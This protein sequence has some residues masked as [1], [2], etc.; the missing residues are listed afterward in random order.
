MDQGLLP[1]CMH[2]ARS[3]GEAVMRGYLDFPDIL[4]TFLSCSA[5]SQRTQMALEAMLVSKQ[6]ILYE[7]S[8]PSFFCSHQVPIND[9]IK[10]HF[11]TRHLSVNIGRRIIRRGNGLLGSFRRAVCLS[12]LCVRKLA[13]SDLARVCCGRAAFHANS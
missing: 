2:A 6:C 8:L 5:V 7:T 13:P 10:D 3:R 4:E 9:N 11:R 1:L 12:R